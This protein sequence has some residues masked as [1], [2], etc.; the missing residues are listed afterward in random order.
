MK[1]FSYLCIYNSPPETNS[2]YRLSW[3]AFREEITLS[4]LELWKT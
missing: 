2:M 1:M 4:K 3:K